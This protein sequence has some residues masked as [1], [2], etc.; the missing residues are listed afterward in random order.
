[1]Q[2]MSAIL[3]IRGFTRIWQK[4]FE[5]QERSIMVVEDL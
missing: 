1:M 3:S 5:L 4:T 2:G